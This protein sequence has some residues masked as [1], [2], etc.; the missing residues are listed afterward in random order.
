[1]LEFIFGAVFGIGVAF[2]F[3]YFV[4]SLKK[5]AIERKRRERIKKQQEQENL[6][7][8]I[9]KVLEEIK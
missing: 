9:R 4:N 3:S 8:T 6:E 2:L 5:D 1:M 7:K